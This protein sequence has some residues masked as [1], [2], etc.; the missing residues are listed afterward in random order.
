[1]RFMQT[2]R[3]LVLSAS[4]AASAGARTVLP[5]QPVE[6]F[7]S[8]LTAALEKYPE[9]FPY[10]VD[11][12]FAAHRSRADQ[13]DAMTLRW[14]TQSTITQGTAHTHYSLL[15][16][17]GKDLEPKDRQTLLDKLTTKENYLF[18]DAEPS[19]YLR[20]VLTHF[21]NGEI[22]LEAEQLRTVVHYLVEFG[23]DTQAQFALNTYGTLL[24]KEDKALAE[25]RSKTGGYQSV[26]SGIR[27]IAQSTSAD[28]ADAK[29]VRIFVHPMF[30]YFFD[31]WDS[32]DEEVTS[33]SI[34]AWIA[35]AKEREGRYNSPSSHNALIVQTQSELH[36]LE[37]LRNYAAP[38]IL[39]LPPALITQ[40]GD[41]WRG[42]ISDQSSV[43]N[44]GR[45][46]ERTIGNNRQV[47]Y[48]ESGS[49][50]T[51]ELSLDDIAKLRTV[52]PPDTALRVEG[53][54][55]SQCLEKAAKQ[56]TSLPNPLA[57]NLRRSAIVGVMGFPTDLS[58][59]LPDLSADAQTKFYDC[60]AE[61]FAE[62]LKDAE[63][64]IK[65]LH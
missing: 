65:L 56:L 19:F 35:G 27:P 9:A 41:P 34:R 5:Y 64:P 8:E 15:E 45:F 22:P 32:T 52:I 36:S 7:R 6:I 63:S 58:C 17:F 24:S 12:V 31:S 29:M 33:A 61:Q 2:L 25:R 20:N 28:F 48:L 38:T 14:A 26:F 13:I 23:N 44:L 51:G 50:G 54:Y 16:N 1:M 18:F 43:Q 47:Y 11:N 49:V 42:D 60:I 57:I 3:T 10:A 37:A 62:Q 59:P 39:I 40:E 21:Q 46:L 30:F 53:G 4:L 55:L